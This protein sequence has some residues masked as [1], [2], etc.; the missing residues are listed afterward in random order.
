MGKRNFGLLALIVGFLLIGMNAFAADGDMIV[1]GSLGVGMTDSPINSKLEVVDSSNPQMRLTNNGTVRTD[2]QTTSN[3][4]LYINPSGG[5]VGIGTASPGNVLE[6]VGSAA[7]RGI[8][9][10]N[11]LALGGN[12]GGS[13][14]VKSPLQPSAAGQRI[15]IFGAGAWDGQ[16]I[17]TPACIQAFSGG[18][19]NSDTLRS[20][21]LTFTTSPTSGGSGIERMRISPSGNVGIG[22]T[23]P[24]YLLTMEADGISYYNQNTDHH[25]WFSGSSGRWKSDARPIANA[26]DTVLKL[27]GVSFKWKKRTDIYETTADGEQKYVSS[28][29]EDN[30]DA[31]DSIGL[32]G[33]DVMK[34]LPQVVDADQ[35]DPNFAAGIAYSKIVALLIE[36]VKEQQKA[37]DDLR[38]EVELLKNR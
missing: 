30:P 16:I 37:I 18:A 26:L 21:Y 35:K 25:E 36:A 33:E 10:S 31:K 15:G 32:I 38:A 8:Y 6:V 17:R 23:N 34:V 7:N 5:N 4:H 9:V 19:W 28:T 11:S 1:N 20:S 22:N 29:W 2:L 3:G 12:S 13:I 27:N 14:M 24:G